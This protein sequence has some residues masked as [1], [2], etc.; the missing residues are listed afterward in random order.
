MAAIASTMASIASGS[1]QKQKV[2][3]YRQLLEAI[4]VS[5][6]VAHAKAFVD[7]SEFHSHCP[8]VSLAYRCIPLWTM[9]ASAQGVSLALPSA[10]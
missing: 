5:S 6:N 9:S 7:H 2:E 10:S 4:I 3:S 8:G 1:D